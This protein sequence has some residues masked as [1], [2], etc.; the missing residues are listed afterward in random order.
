MQLGSL[1]LD[2]K[3][4]RKTQFAVC[5]LVICVVSGVCFLSSGYFGS[6]VVAFILL[7]TLSVIAMFFDILPVSVFSRAQ[8]Y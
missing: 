4:E 6:E 3:L 5:L 2:K 7:L 1:L 8:C